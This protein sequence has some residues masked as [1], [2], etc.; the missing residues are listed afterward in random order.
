[1][2][3]NIRPGA[4]V[5]HR[6]GEIVLAGTSPH[7]TGFTLSQDCRAAPRIVAW[8]VTRWLGVETVEVANEC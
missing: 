6:A 1:M 2:I 3:K 5:S 7:N 8:R 4:L